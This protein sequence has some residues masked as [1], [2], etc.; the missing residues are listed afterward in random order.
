MESDG[1]KGRLRERAIEAATT[2]F[3][4]SGYSSVSM[5]EIAASLGVSKAA[6]YYHFADKQ[7]LM[8]AILEGYL[9]DIERL[10]E[11]QVLPRRTCRERIGSFVRLVFTQPPGTRAIMR[12][13]SQESGKL[14]PVVR[15]TFLESY[16]R[17]FIGRLET[18]LAEG[19]ARGELRAMDPKAATWILLG[20]MYPFFYGEVL[21]ER[22]DLDTLDEQIVSIFVDGA[23]R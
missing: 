14:D 22:N 16:H 7:T 20:M 23:A 8:L 2:M 21:A 9:V 17:R 5:R 6:L 12:L 4:R 10:I 19:V 13:A 1:E 18:I 11:E 3:V 15:A